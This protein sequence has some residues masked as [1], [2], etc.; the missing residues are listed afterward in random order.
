[1]IHSAAVRLWVAASRGASCQRRS[2]CKSFSAS[3][4]TS[5]LQPRSTFKTTLASFNDDANKMKQA[6]QGRT[7]TLGHGLSVGLSSGDD[8]K[9]KGRIPSFSFSSGQWF[10]RCIALDEKGTPL[11]INNAY[12]LWNHQPIYNVQQLINVN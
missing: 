4:T 10:P 1:M 8:V 11:N 5:H 9:R 12:P 2:C 3:P 6:V 7:S